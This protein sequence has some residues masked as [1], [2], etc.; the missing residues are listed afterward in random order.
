MKLLGLGAALLLFPLCGYAQSYADSPFYKLVDG[1]P[2]SAHADGYAH[3]LIHANGITID[4]SISRSEFAIDHISRYEIAADVE[5]HK[6]VP[7]QMFRY[8]MQYNDLG[9]TFGYNLL[10]QPVE[11]TDQIKCTFSQLTDPDQ[12]WWSRDKGIA[13]VDLPADLTPLVIHSGQVI[14]IS[15]YPAG[16]DKPAVIHYVQLTR[17]DAG[18]A[19][20]A[21]TD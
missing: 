16:Q 4:L 3:G 20:E 21:K 12:P 19:V 14:A 8:Y 13:P 9:A 7:K 1:V 15:T 18:R 2:A 17:K 10:V 6:P 11:G 5:R